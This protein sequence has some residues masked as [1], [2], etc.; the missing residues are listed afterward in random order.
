MSSIEELERRLAALET[1]VAEE[2]ELRAA[3][4][5]DQSELGSKIRATHH[6]VQAL[7]ITQSEQTETLEAIQRTMRTKFDE[8]GRLLKRIID[9]LGKLIQQGE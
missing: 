4:D 2:A 5:R 3:V 6:L 9:M 1:K 7:A 8:H